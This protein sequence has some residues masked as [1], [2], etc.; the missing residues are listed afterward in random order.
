MNEYRDTNDNRNEIMRIISTILAFIVLFA[1]MVVVIPPAHADDVP[2]VTITDYKVSPAVM[3]PDSI[4][5]VTITVKNTASTSSV[6]EKSGQ[7]S[8]DV[9]AVVRTSDTS[10]NIQNVHLEGNGINV[11]TKDFDAVGALGPGQSIPITFSIQ[12][13]DKSGM[14]Y[15]EVWIDVNGGRSTKYPIPVNVNT[16]TGIQKQ[17]ILIMDSSLTGSV[18][19][20]EEVP[21][22]LTITNAGQILADDVTLRIAN[23][24][25]SVA[26]KTSD[27]YNLGTIGA[28]EQ[29]TVSLILLTD[30]ATNPGLVRVPVTIGYTTIDGIPTTQGTGIDVMM[31]GVAELGFV[32]VDS[33]PPRLVEKQPFDLTVRIENT[34]TGEAKQVSAKVDLPAEGT[35]EAFIGKIKP[36]NDAPAIFLLE[37]MKGG[38]YPYNLTISYTDDM[39]P[40]TLIRQMNMRVPPSDNS[41]NIILVLIILAILGFLA[42]RYWYLPSKNG[43]GSFPWAKK[44]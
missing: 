33:N 38:D 26:P 8:Q 4:G 35:R 42:Y 29:K 11:Q 28:G 25:E 15:P 40:H 27:L 10:V 7:L 20:G 23:V 32:S 37:G 13:P 17:A 22:S 9:Y 43:D 12:A 36:G 24:S 21:V 44:N 5:T 2:T 1:L 41:G 16:A 18:N 34:G 39:G 3:M 19:P 14:Y 6:S 31:K 30:K